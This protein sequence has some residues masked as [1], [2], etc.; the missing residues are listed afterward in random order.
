M[1]QVVHSHEFIRIY[2]ALSPDLC[3][4]IM[5]KF[6]AD[7]NK[8][9][10]RTVNKQGEYGVEEDTKKTFDLEIPIEGSWKDIFQKVHIAIQECIQ[11][12]I[13]HSPALQSVK[14]Q[15]SGYKIQMYK[16]GEGYFRWHADSLGVGAME[17]VFAV[18]LYIN[19]VEKGGE[20]EFYHQKLKVKP[21]AGHLMIFPTAWNYMHCGQTPLSGD[22]YIITSFGQV[23]LGAKKD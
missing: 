11:E 14:L 22:K 12:Y 15:A 13:S 5:T 10:G 19:D 17:R 3:Q 7:E 23:I 9:Q 4:E 20:T 2:R 21:K 18:I 8:W 1:P 6:D 16:K